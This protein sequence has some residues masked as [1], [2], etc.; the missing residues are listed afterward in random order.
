MV[1][2]KEEIGDEEE[3]G[4]SLEELGRNTVRRIWGGERR[5]W[6]S[7]LGREGKEELRRD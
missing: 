7:K 2:S 4:T 3:L 5:G 6:L 1:R